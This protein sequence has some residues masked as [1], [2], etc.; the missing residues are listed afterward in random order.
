KRCARFP[1]DLLKAL[2][3]QES[4]DHEPAVRFL[5]YYAS[6]VRTHAAQLLE[7]DLSN[8][9]HLALAPH[10]SKIQEA[11]VASLQ[12]KSLPTRLMAALALLSLDERQAKANEVLQASA[13]SAETKLL[14]ETSGL[15]GAARLAS[16]QAI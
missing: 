2:T 1:D 3:N 9:V 8:P 11:L 5:A 6:L 13:A 4:V 15:I 14:A 10:T 12:A 7:K 16:P